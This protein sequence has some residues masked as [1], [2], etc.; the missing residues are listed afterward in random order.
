MDSVRQ[1]T[2]SLQLLNRTDDPLNVAIRKEATA[3]TTN[4]RTQT[5]LEN[6]WGHRRLKGTVA[7]EEDNRVYYFG[8]EREVLG[9]TLRMPVVLMKRILESGLFAIERSSPLGFLLRS[10]YPAIDVL[11]F[12]HEQPERGNKEMVYLCGAVGSWND[13]IM[14][15]TIHC[16]V[17]RK[18]HSKTGFLLAKPPTKHY[19]FIL[20]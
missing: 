19:H 1:G 18:R 15:P 16:L 13:D 6:V 7:Y 14:E 4:M 12:D 3:I 11:R 8:I 2:I 20:L 10:E 17:E 5:R 9:K